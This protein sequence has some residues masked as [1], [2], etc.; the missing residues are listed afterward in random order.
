MPAAAPYSA[1][2]RP[3]SLQH[4]VR[5]V[6]RIAERRGSTWLA[7]GATL[8]AGSA[9]AI[10]IVRAGTVAGIVADG[11]RNHCLPVA[12]VSAGLSQRRCGQEDDE[13]Q[14]A[15]HGGRLSHPWVDAG[16]MN[17]HGVWTPIGTSPS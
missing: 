12:L 11:L 1:L 17:R 10:R 16:A 6:R 2:L 8:S 7:V 4:R 5:D 15:T 13:C 9:G 3:P 14:S